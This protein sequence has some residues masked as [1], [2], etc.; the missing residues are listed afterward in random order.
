MRKIS[1]YG[2]ISIFALGFCF[3]FGADVCAAINHS[4]RQQTLFSKVLAREQFCGLSLPSYFKS[5]PHFYI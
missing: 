4:F 5:T 3:I 2:L 1:L